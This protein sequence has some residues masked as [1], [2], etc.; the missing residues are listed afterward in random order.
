MK[1]ESNN[2]VQTIRPLDQA[3]TSPSSVPVP[4]KGVDEMGHIFNQEVELNS[5]A[6]S[7]RKMGLRVSPVEQ[8]VQLYNQ[9]GH[10]AQKSM[11][12]ISR[13]IIEQL[14]K[15]VSTEELVSLA[16]GDPA[17]AFVVLNYVTAQADSEVRPSEAALARDAIAQLQLRFKGEIQAGLNIATALQAAVADPHERQKLR[18][19]YYASVVTRQSLATMMQALL[20][21][22]SG[23][24]FRDV[25]N[26]MR[27]ALADDLAALVS[28]MP[29]PLLR[30]LLLGLQSC[31]QLSAVLSGCHTLIQR[32]SIEHDAVSLLQR[33]LGYAGG[34]ISVD[35]MLRLGNDLGGG[36]VDRQMASLNA[37]YPLFQQ[38]PLAL[39]PDKRVR[40]ESLQILLTLIGELDRAVRGPLR[41]AGEPRPM[42]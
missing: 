12:S 5:R 9:L 7:G 28:S 22:Y 36:P 19:L 40:Q 25:L 1:V 18:Q 8:L 37:L 32:L 17:R 15:S 27:K 24:R 29:T 42:T 31:G 21:D 39:W 23:E 41:F 35:E 3:V 30:T 13:S 33:I 10:P 4:A 11:A 14:R 34:G 16:G 6:L 2:D 20:G 38:L 26:A